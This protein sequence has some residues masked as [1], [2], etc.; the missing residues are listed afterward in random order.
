MRLVHIEKHGR[1][2]SRCDTAGCAQ[3]SQ[4]RDFL[5][6]T[7]RTTYTSHRQQT[8][9]GR[10]GASDIRYS[11]EVLCTRTRFIQ[12]GL[13]RRLDYELDVPCVRL[14]GP[15][16]RMEQPNK[17]RHMVAESCTR[18]VGRKGYQHHS[19]GFPRRSAN[20]RRCSSL[21]WVQYGR[22][23]VENDSS[24]ALWYLTSSRRHARLA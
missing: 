16:F 6:Q 19:A 4:S 22:R 10:D 21:A 5:A 7:L 14:A 11:P 1:G 13:C 2:F 9:E 20:Q 17:P 23:V 8:T 18:L 24:P 3:V 12:A 15:V